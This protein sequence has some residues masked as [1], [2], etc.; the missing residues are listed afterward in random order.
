MNRVKVKPKCVSEPEGRGSRVEGVV[1]ESEGDDDRGALGT[2][3]SWQALEIDLER[4]R[5]RE[6][7]R[8]GGETGP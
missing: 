2:A 1:P 3:S 7:E 5:E 6:R 8:E 4:E